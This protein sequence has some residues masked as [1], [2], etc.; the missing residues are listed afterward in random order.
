MK[1]KHGKKISSR[2]DG[3]KNEP[4]APQNGKVFQ[5]HRPFSV[6]EQHGPYPHSLRCPYTGYTEGVEMRGP[7]ATRG[8]ST[9]RVCRPLTPL[10]AA[11]LR[12]TKPTSTGL[13]PRHA[14]DVVDVPPT[15]LG[16]VAGMVANA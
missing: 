14:R 11:K 5:K 2:P 9:R 4:F 15:V 10:K 1:E 6:Q 3:R 8:N 13:Q 16:L 7:T 12:D